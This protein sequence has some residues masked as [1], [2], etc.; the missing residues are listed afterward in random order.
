MKECSI[1]KKN[2]KETRII[3]SKGQ[4]Y[5]RKHYLQ[6]YK[7][8]KIDYTIYDDNEYIITENFA[9]IVLKDK[10][11]TITGKA[12]IDKED[13]EK[14][15]QYKWHI[16]KSLNTNYAISTL[17]DG[18]KLFLHRFI[19][20]YKG[21]D[22]VDHINHNGLDNRKSNLRIVSHSR[23]LLNQYKDYKGIKKVPSGRY[24]VSIFV[25]GNSKYLGTYNTL[26]EALKVRKQ[27][28]EKY[29]N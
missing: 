19:L 24:Q 13:I 10:K 23:N 29:F 15:K 20:N 4:H 11:G 12:I 27:E 25:D 8:G 6:L 14:C 1:C 7:H 22:D 26:E 2:D 18:K 16:R 5:C 3:L 28:E 9:E 17:K 21:K